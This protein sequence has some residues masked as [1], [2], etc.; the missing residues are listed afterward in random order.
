[1]T[2][3]LFWFGLVWFGLVWFGLVWFGLVW[4][5]FFQKKN[6]TKPNQNKGFLKNKL[7]KIIKM[8]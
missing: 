5:F 7:I 2:S 1:M 6:Q 3:P 8:E 4:F